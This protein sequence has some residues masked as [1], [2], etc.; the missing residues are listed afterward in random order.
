MVDIVGYL[1][2]NDLIVKRKGGKFNS[3]ATYT[4]IHPTFALKQHLWQFYLDAEQ[5]IDEPYITINKGT[6]AAKEAIYNLPDDHPERMQMELINDF[7]RGHT[8]ACKGPVKL[9]YAPALASP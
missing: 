9:T 1:E 6:D 2:A 3:G 7:L 5:P 4:R 8:W